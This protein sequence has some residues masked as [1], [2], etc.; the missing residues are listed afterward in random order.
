[1]PVSGRT[2]VAHGPPWQRSILV[3]EKLGDIQ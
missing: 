1:M 3:S 2:L